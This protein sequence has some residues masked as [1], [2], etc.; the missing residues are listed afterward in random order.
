MVEMV[1]RQAHILEFWVRIPIAQPI[2]LRGRLEVVPAWSHK[3]ITSVRFRPTATNLSSSRM[4]G[5]R[6]RWFEKP[7]VKVRFLGAT[8]KNYVCG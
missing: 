5:P 4:A 1:S 2:I 8:P 3:P 7:E 6:V